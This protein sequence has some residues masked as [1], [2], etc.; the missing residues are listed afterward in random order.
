VTSRGTVPPSFDLVTTGNVCCD[1]YVPDHVRPPPGGLEL[2]PS[3]EAV[4]G[5]NAA[6][7]AIT[8]SC[9]GLRAAVA[10]ALGDDLIGRQLRRHLEEAGVDA[11]LIEVRPGRS[12]PATLVFNDPVTAERSFVHHP[13]TN[14]D[15]SLPE[16]A[17]RAHCRVFHLAAPELL[18]GLWP[19]AALAAARRMKSAGA[20]VTLDTFAVEGK[21]GAGGT[22]EL[23]REHRPLLEVVDMVFPNEIE[24]R[25][26]TGQSTLP[27]IT[28]YFHDLG[29]RVAVIKRGAAGCTVSWEG[30]T[31][32][33]PAPC[34]QAVDTCGAGDT[35]SAG[36]IA[37]FVA[38]LD[39]VDS[40]RLGC[41]V[42]ALCVT[43]RGATTAVEDPD[44]LASA[45]SCL[46]LPV[47]LTVRRRDL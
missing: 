22:D 37:G 10:G 27:D 12:S 43:A 26:V 39:P 5:G 4:A 20:T 9:L 38:G 6:N 46:A 24:A 3:F 47:D 2:I 14:A 40:A 19:G 7:T 29:A 18:P 35:F 1:I 30:R 8:A 31:V 45:L 11:S 23:V 34:V 44:R 28:K 42:G 21:S 36:Y 41:A 17:F 25:L 33:V 13:G 15:L 16:A 32:E